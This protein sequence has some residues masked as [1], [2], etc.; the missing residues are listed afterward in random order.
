MNVTHQL[1][2]VGVTVTRDGLVAPVKQ[3]PHRS[4]AP[5]ILTCYE[6]LEFPYQLLPAAAL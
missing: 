3:V 4:M 5:V 2:E 6:L 1:Q